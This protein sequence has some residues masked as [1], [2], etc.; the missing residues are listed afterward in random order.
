WNILI[1][2]TI[3]AVIG[4]AYAML[5]T[6]IYKADALIQIEEK[7]GGASA[8][9]N[10]DMADMFGGG[11]SSST[12]ETEIIKSRMVLGKTVDKLN[13]TTVVTPDYMPV[14]GAGLARLQG[15]S[16]VAHI[17]RFIVP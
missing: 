5:A 12:T 4:I 6:P 1:I 9:L 16:I 15:E 2:T 14:I 10:S 11:K 17:S 8:L 7:S 13:L 3:F